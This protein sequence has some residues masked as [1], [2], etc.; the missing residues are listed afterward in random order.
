MALP[1]ITKVRNTPVDGIHLV[2]TLAGAPTGTP[3]FFAARLPGVAFEVTVMVFTDQPAAGTTVVNTGLTDPPAP[4]SLV[5]SG[6][7]ASCTGT[8]VVAGTDDG[9]QAQ[10]ENFILAGTA[11]IAGTKTFKTITSV[12]IPTRGAAGDQVQ[13]RSTGTEVDATGAGTSWTI[14]IPLDEGTEIRLPYY[15][16]VED[17]EGLCEEEGFEWLCIG[18]N[19]DV[20]NQV[21][22][23]LHDLLVDNRKA[24]DRSLQIWVTLN[25]NSDNFAR[26]DVPRIAKVLKGY[27]AFADN[28][29]EK[30]P[31]VSIR[32]H[33]IAEDLWFG[34]PYTDK[35]PVTG[36]IYV[37][38]FHQGK[39]SLEAMVRAAGMGV[40]NIINQAHNLNIALDCGLTMKASHCENFHTDEQ[41]FPEAGG[42][43]CVGEMSFS[44]DLY[45]GKLL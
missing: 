35:C 9:D 8:V 36:T 39:V 16:A 40:F 34:Q 7:Q 1:V 41:S 33:D 2:V 4:R 32:I 19:L 28:A 6:S 43:L 10:S 25:T 12:T 17:D 11:N 26:G 27:P 23:A 20:P 37:Y 15:V 45:L 42:A 13:V 21:E 18:T 38:V 3:Q 44:G 24:L 22:A 31:I 29:Q 30:Y 14:E 5:V